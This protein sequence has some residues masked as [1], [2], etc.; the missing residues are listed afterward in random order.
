MVSAACWERSM[1]AAPRRGESANRAH[2]PPHRHRGAAA[3]PCALRGLFP[4]PARA[5]T[6]RSPGVTGARRSLPKYRGSLR[7][8]RLPRLFCTVS[9]PLSAV[10]V[11][12]PHPRVKRQPQ[13]K[14]KLCKG[15]EVMD[16]LRVY[17]TTQE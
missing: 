13:G 4:A 3:E 17:G 12:L 7:N 11:F 14:K 8:R 6:E 2:P 5:C 1:L 9:L 16:L 15:T 10:Q